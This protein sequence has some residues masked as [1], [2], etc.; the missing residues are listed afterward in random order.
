MDVV[1]LVKSSHILAVQEVLKQ[2]KIVAFFSVET[3]LEKENMNNVMME[4]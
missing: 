4:I 2:Q 1:L 3:E